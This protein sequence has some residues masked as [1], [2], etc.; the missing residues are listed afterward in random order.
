LRFVEN[1]GDGPLFAKSCYKRVLDFARTVVTDKRVQPNHAWQ[2]G[3][4]TISSNLGL[5][6]RVVD[7]IQDHAARTA[8]EDYGDVSV[9]TMARVVAVIPRIAIGPTD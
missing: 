9:I 4:K 1:S 3:F 5:D 8:G 7:A 6:H 2:L